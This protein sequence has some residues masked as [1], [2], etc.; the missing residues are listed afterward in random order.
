MLPAP[1]SLS[2]IPLIFSEQSARYPTPNPCLNWSDERVTGRT[3]TQREAVCITWNWTT[4]RLAVDVDIVAAQQLLFS[5]AGL[6]VVAEQRTH[7]VEHH[8]VFLRALA[9][10]C[11]CQGGDRPG[12][13]YSFWGHTVD[14]TTG[15]EEQNSKDCMEDDFVRGR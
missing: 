6:G 3:L 12:K 13:H 14:I 5:D 2:E 9:S 11:K 4:V 8:A 10:I 1:G 7:R 15:I